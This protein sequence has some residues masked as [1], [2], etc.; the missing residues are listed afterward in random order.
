M[1]DLQ[2]RGAEDAEGMER[3]AKPRPKIKTKTE[4]AEKKMRIAP[5]EVN[6][7][8]RAMKLLDYDSSSVAKAI[9]EG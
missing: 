9:C 3:K 2:H 6:A 8:Q 7:N 4:V 1:E 5:G